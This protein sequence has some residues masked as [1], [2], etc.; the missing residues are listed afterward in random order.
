MASLPKLIDQGAGLIGLDDEL[1]LLEAIAAIARN[2][3]DLAG[4]L[5]TP[6][7]ALKLLDKV[8]T[9]IGSNDVKN[10]FGALHLDGAYADLARL[11]GKVKDAAGK[12]PEKYKT[13][14]KPLSDFGEVDGA[15]EWGLDGSREAELGSRIKLKVSG[16]AKLQFAAAAKAT[17]G[18][19]R[20]DGLLKLGVHAGVTAQAGAK[21]PIRWGTFDASGGASVEV[22]LDYF[23]KPAA[24]DTLYGVALV[25]RILKLPDPFDY[26]SI[27]NAFHAGQALQ[28]IVY[29]F[30]DKANAKADLAL[31]ASGNLIEDIL[32]DVKLTIG[33]S[34]EINSAFLLSLRALPD[35]G[36]KVEIMLGRTSA[37]SAGLSLGVEVKLDGSALLGRVREVLNKAVARSDEILGKITP[38]LT[39]GTW[40]REQG[41]E[42]IEKLAGKLVGDPA[43]EGLRDALV[44]DLK[45]ALGGGEPDEAAI[46]KWLSDKL[47]DAIDGGARDLTELGDGLVDKLAARVS[48]ALP[49]PAE[50]RASLVARAKGELGPLVE[51]V[52]GA[53]RGELEKLVALPGNALGKALKKVNAAVS[54]QIDSLDKAL[55]PVRKL[56]D[57]YN[58]VLKLAQDFAGD[59][60]RAKISASVKIEEY[61]KWGEEEKIVGTFTGPE[62]GETF[63]KIATGDV[64]ELKTL[65]LDHKATP[66]FELDGKRSHIKRSAQRTSKA[67][68]EL[69]MFGFNQSG[70][71]TLDGKADL[72]IDGDGNVQVDATGEL[73]S[74][75]KT[76]TEQ[77]EVSFVDT[78]SLKL[79]KA[80]DGTPLETRTVEVGVSIAHVDKEL[81]LEELT[82]FVDSLAHAGL[83]SSDTTTGAEARYRVWAPDG[84]PIAADIS[85]KLQLTPSQICAFMHVAPGDRLPD[86]KLT[87]A[88]K[89]RLIAAA[90]AAGEAYG[91]HRSNVRHGQQ[92]VENEYAL[93]PKPLADFLYDRVREA[94]TNNDF[95]RQI[96]GNETNV[97]QRAI[98]NEYRRMLALVSMVQ[99]L[100][101]I[102]TAVPRVDGNSPAGAW[103]EKDY[104]RAEH[105]LAQ[106]CSRWLHTGGGGF[107]ISDEVAAVTVSFLAA[108]CDLVG[109]AR[110]ADGTDAMALTLAGTPPGQAKRQETPLT[111][112]ARGAIPA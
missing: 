6:A 43:L 99:R 58:R 75:F 3:K 18:E 30:K 4:K 48:D 76:G 38:Y 40:L 96:A 10:A 86:G 13:L 41:G 85:A 105:A 14:L 88:V 98:V 1:A 51:K 39:P 31:S 32:A 92:G 89:K 20:A 12:I 71:V 50:L 19:T 108:V 59:T 91:R 94:G 81:K 54:E 25:E 55:A 5:K 36:G 104:A 68:V 97:D 24:R 87:E 47:T 34:A 83:V 61:W 111:D 64:G 26:A 67:G 70:S 22:G 78:V 72:L 79:A 95:T 56:I 15:V 52:T 2:W 27:W 53:L 16:E 65:L 17:I 63:R 100:G 42:E 37:F 103:S 112:T 60:S 8:L 73:K 77:R 102:Y 84:K 80:A 21:L 29:L 69:V 28:G 57:E 101:D 9:D 11:A 82:G 35:S 110:T 33:A 93:V 7:D 62:A 74:R 49:V 45:A 66:G 44:T 46:V 107:K 23:Y 106:D 109:I 90:V